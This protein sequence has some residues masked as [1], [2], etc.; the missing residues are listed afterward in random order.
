MLILHGAEDEHFPLAQMEQFR[1]A[2]LTAGNRCELQVFP[3]GH[4]FF[5]HGRDENRPYHATLKAVE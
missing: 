3:G 1:D 4:G 5:N 2:M